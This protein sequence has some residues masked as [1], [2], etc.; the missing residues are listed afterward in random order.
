MY[1]NRYNIP[2]MTVSQPIVIVYAILPP[3]RI[4]LLLSAGMVADRIEARMKVELRKE[5]DGWH[6]TGEEGST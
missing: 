4:N 2:L 6:P 5:D 3:R 1:D